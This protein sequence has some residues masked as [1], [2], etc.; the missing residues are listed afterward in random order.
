MLKGQRDAKP[1]EQAR[2]QDHF[3]IVVDP[4]KE[5]VTK[6]PGGILQPVEI[7]KYGS[8]RNSINNINSNP[9]V[10]G[11]ETDSNTSSFDPEAVN[12][13]SPV[14]YTGEAHFGRLPRQHYNNRRPNSMHTTASGSSSSNPKTRPSSISTAASSSWPVRPLI[15]T[16]GS[17]SPVGSSHGSTGKNTKKNNPP[18]GTPPLDV[19]AHELV[20]LDPT[21]EARKKAFLTPMQERSNSVRVSIVREPSPLSQSTLPPAPLKSK[22]EETCAFGTPAEANGEPTTTGPMHLRDKQAPSNVYKSRKQIG[23]S[24]ETEAEKEEEDQ[25]RRSPTLAE[26]YAASQ[27]EAEVEFGTFSG[28][29]APTPGRV[30]IPA[31]TAAA[32]GEGE[33]S[34]VSTLGPDDPQPRSKDVSPVSDADDF[35]DDEEF[36]IRERAGHARQGVGGSL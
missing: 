30:V 18:G 23:D 4:F 11:S 19:P 32:P 15:M 22:R 2:I 9:F 14:V 34:P 12:Y 29:H 31:V 3:E 16:P 28:V 5:Y 8:R 27:L 36:P 20:K 33:V 17:N 1:T 26:A 24:Y 13:T 21:A 6:H 25:G 7:D 35:D 10:V